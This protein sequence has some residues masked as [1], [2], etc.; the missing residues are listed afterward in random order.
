MIDNFSMHFQQF[1]DLKFQLFFSRGT[2]SLDPPKN[3]AE[4]PTIRSRRD[5]PDFA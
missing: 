2:M 4:C 1:E 3:L 5:C